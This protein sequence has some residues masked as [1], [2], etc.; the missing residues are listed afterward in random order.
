MPA[1][2]IRRGGIALEWWMSRHAW[3]GDPSVSAQADLRQA[4]EWMQDG[5]VA[6]AVDLLQRLVNEAALDDKG[7]AAAYVWLAESRA[8]SGFKLRCLERA[9][10]FD[11]DNQQIR[12]GLHQLKAAPQP[13]DL[14]AMSGGGPGA[15]D[16]TPGV[17]GVVGGLNGMASG[18]FVDGSGMIATTSYGIGAI[19]RVT[20]TLDGGRHLRG[21]VL[22][23]YPT[24][25]LA[26]IET[27]LRLARKPSTPPPSMI[28]ENTAFVALGYG[29]IRLRG[30]L[31]RLKDRRARHW[32]RTTISPARLP[33][34]GGNPLYDEKGQLLGL[35]TR[36]VD[37]NGFSLAL[38]ISH[39]LALAER[40][41]RDRQLMPGAALCLA[42]GSLTR[43][44]LYGG[45]H[46]ET[47]GAA[48]DHGAM[49]H[50]QA[51]KLAALR[52][53]NAALPCPHCGAR[54]GEYEGRCLRCGHEWAKGAVLES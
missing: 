29:G 42:C 39:I 2:A 27:G 47:C 23:R 36:N 21:A 54:V 31:G 18:A 48:Q 43:A 3:E 33:D 11:P 28:A 4:I 13:G 41:R 46:C 40:L 53:E 34:A 45:C 24:R 16:E 44:R 9:L 5:E 52:R 10:A 17:V 1:F 37:G 14:P 38:K 32:L 19:A 6:S 50:P 20:V 8:D 12:Q 25:D 35:L 30:A 15:L 51:E 7:R 49:A 22:R 26:L